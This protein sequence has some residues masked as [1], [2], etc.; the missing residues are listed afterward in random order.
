MGLGYGSWVQVCILATDL[1]SGSLVRACALAVGLGY[2]YADYALSSGLAFGMRRIVSNS[3]RL[4]VQMLLWYLWY[5]SACAQ[6][7][8]DCSQES[9]LNPCACAA[10]VPWML[11]TVASNC[12]VHAAR[13]CLQPLTEKLRRV[14]SRVQEAGWQTLPGG[15]SS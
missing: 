6:C 3:S 8:R 11:L 12:D 15:V 2:E 1:G 13:R 4:H 9:A 14:V 5:L 7:L 10:V